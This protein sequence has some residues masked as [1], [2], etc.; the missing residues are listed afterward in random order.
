MKFPGTFHPHRGFYSDQAA[1]PLES[2]EKEP[3]CLC[4]AWK[5]ASGWEEIYSPEYPY[6]CQ[7]TQN[8]VSGMDISQVTIP[9]PSKI[10]S[11]YHLLSVIDFIL[12]E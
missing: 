1:E 6:P 12:Y 9:N 5:K 8:S 7:N 10:K 3:G 11:V 4:S 2:P